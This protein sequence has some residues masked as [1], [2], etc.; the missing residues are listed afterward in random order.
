[1]LRAMVG[2]FSRQ[3]REVSEMNVIRVRDETKIRLAAFKRQERFKNFD[4]AL[5]FLLDFY[6]RKSGRRIV[7][8]ESDWRFVR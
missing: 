8:T 2:G 6:E 7:V 4:D 3:E 1:M 5:S